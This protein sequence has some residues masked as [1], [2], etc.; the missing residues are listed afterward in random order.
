MEYALTAFRVLLP[1]TGRN[2]AAGQASTVDYFAEEMLQRYPGDYGASEDV[3]DM[4][5]T[6][7]TIGASSP[8]HAFRTSQSLL[9]DRGAAY[10]RHGKPDEVATTRGGIAVELWKYERPGDPLLLGFVEEDFDGQAGASK[11]VPSL[12][13][14]SPLLRDQLCHLDTRLCSANA[15]PTSP[16]LITNIS[17]NNVRSQTGSSARVLAADRSRTGVSQLQTSARKGV[18]TVNTAMTT[19]DYLRKFTHQVHPIVQVYGLDRASG[20]EPRL[21]MAFAIPGERGAGRCIR[22]SFA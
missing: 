17:D 20:G 3:S 15:D 2:K 12:L 10:I 18:E 6:A 8:F 7:K 4:A 21:V 1:R 22:S 13:S 9:D 14:I 5:M 16:N 19:D 11:M